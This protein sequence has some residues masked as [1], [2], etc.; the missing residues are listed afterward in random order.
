MANVGEPDIIQGSDPERTF[1]R[2]VIEELKKSLGQKK[3]NGSLIEYS[4]LQDF[5]LDIAVFMKW[6][7]NRFTMRFFELKA[8]V[9]S[10]QGG[11]GF[12]NS[13][14]KGSQVDLLLLENSQLDLANQFIRWMLVDGTKPKGSERFAIFDNIQAKN[15]A[16]GGIK[17]GKQNNFRVNDL[18]NNATTWANFLKE[19]GSFL[20]SEEGLV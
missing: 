20:I 6:S 3:S 11:V 17:R 14:G 8:F 16:M 10:R 2:A 1:Q 7:N 12:G 5:G 15:A 18:I 19:L 13:Q 4:I 9:G